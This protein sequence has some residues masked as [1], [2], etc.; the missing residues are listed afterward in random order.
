MIKIEIKRSKMEIERIKEKFYQK[1]LKNISS[2]ELDFLLQLPADISNILLKKFPLPSDERMIKKYF[3]KHSFISKILMKNPATFK[4][5]ELIYTGKGIQGAIDQY[6]FGSLSSQALRNKLSSVVARVGTMIK[7]KINKKNRMKILNLGS[8]SGRDTIGFLSGVSYL[9]N[10]VS[11]DCIDVDPEALQKGNELIKGENYGEINFIEGNLLRLSYRKEID[12]GLMIGVLC[13]LENRTCIAVLKRIRRYFK[14]GGILIASNVSKNMPEK[15]PFMSYLLKEIIGWKF[16]YKNSEELHEI[17][18]KAG[19][20][21][22]GIF[23]D[24]PTKFHGMGIGVVP[25]S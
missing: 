5:L 7:I 25:Y 20:K 3:R 2:E 23:Y 6:A 14:E 19:Y 9:I 4:M 18:E 12:L 1:F 10:F 16:V 21:W 15:D 13:G 17:F 8:G 24:E 22:K 11:I